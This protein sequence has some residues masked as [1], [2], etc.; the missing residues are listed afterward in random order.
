MP[1]FTG[2]SIWQRIR[3]DQT[4]E[5]DENGEDEEHVRSSLQR[6]NWQGLDTREELFFKVLPADYSP[7]R[8]A[9]LS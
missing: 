3:G 9:E 1:S 8:E 2:R 4:T 6:S 5:S 7:H